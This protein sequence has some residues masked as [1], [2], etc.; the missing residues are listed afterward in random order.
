MYVF[1][2]PHAEF[3]SPQH[4]TRADVLFTRHITV[5]YPTKS[6]SMCGLTYLGIGGTIPSDGTD[7][8][9]ET[10]IYPP[11]AH[12]STAHTSKP[13]LPSDATALVQHV[14]E[15]ALA[16]SPFCHT[17]QCQNLLRYVVKHSLAGEE[18]L[19]RERVIGAEVFGRRP[20]YD[21]GEDPVVRIRAA[22]VRKRLAQFYQSSSKSLTPPEVHIEIPPGSYRAS[23]LWREDLQAV[24]E[25]PYGR[26]ASATGSS[27]LASP[28][29]PAKPEVALAAVEPVPL[30]AAVDPEHG[31]ILSRRK[32][33]AM[34]LWSVV[35]VTV[36]LCSLAGYWLGGTT[37]KREFRAFWQPWSSSSKPVI[38]A[39]GSNA[40]YRLSDQLTDRYAREHNLET[41][42]MEFFVPTGPD[43]SITGAD[44]QPAVNSFVALGD[45]AAVSTIVAALTSQQQPFQERFPDDISFAELR[46]NPT[47][48]VGGFNNPMTI[49][50]T[51]DL[52]FV[53]RARNEI[54]DTGSPGQRWMLHAPPDSHNTEDYAIITRLA[55][56]NGDA[57]ILSVAGMGQYGT[58]AASGFIT[59]PS[60]V[61][62]LVHRLPK[63][64]ADHNLQ[65]VLHVRVVDFK[66]A[67]AEIVAVRTW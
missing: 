48:L 59:N 5:R 56:R 63:G 10:L 24:P 22:E 13:E 40:V 66:P 6:C 43:S 44:I 65:A 9:M 35:A 8:S 62:Q 45:V 52:P 25:M 26:A 23:F 28:I 55:Q 58:L 39:V 33:H 32:V 61:A 60:S 57:P 7:V 20:D 64:W 31:P 54:D 34:V 4:K 17:Q 18:H 15:E 21:T 50:L 53:L 19:L 46:N 42:G 30:H 11:A 16:S 67:S 38:I 1:A 51:K 12:E 14:L 36:L 41:Q 29:E 47:V 3:F 27:L 37:Q 49:E 2:T